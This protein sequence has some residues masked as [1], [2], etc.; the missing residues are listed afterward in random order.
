MSVVYYIGTLFKTCLYRAIQRIYRIE[1]PMGTEYYSI[2]DPD[3]QTSNMRQTNVSGKWYTRVRR[4]LDTSNQKLLPFKL[5][6]IESVGVVD[7]NDTNYEL[8]SEC[9]HYYNTISGDGFWS[10]VVTFR[11]PVVGD[12]ASSSNI[13][14]IPFLEFPIIRGTGIYEGARMCRVEYQQDERKSR[15]INVFR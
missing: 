15:I 2:L 13:T 11:Q 3:L 7:E 8:L 14:T 1:A 5:L 6:T 4:A 12:S 10:A 9:I